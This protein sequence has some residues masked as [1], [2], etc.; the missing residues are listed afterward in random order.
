ML[1]FISQFISISDVIN[2]IKDNALPV[3]GIVFAG[4]AGLSWFM[5]RIALKVLPSKKFFD[6]LGDKI[7]EQLVKMSKK[8]KDSAV[9]TAYKIAE[10]CDEIK[11]DVLSFIKD[12]G[13]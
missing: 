4:G 2:I 11:G 1:E 9:A 12:M 13:R 6:W 7:K 3:I 10:A 5:Y 8:S